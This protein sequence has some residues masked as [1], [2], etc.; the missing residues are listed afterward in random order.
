VGSDYGQ[1]DAPSDVTFTS[2][3]SATWH[4]CG[5]SGSGEAICWGNSFHGRASPPPGTF[6]AVDAGAYHGCG[7]SISS[8]LVCW[9]SDN[10]GNQNV[11]DG[12]TVAFLSANRHNTCALDANGLASCWGCTWTGDYGQC[13]V[14]IDFGHAPPP[15]PEAPPT[16]SVPPSTPPPSIPPPPPP[17]TFYI[18]GDRSQI[19]F[20]TN[21]ECTLELA[22]GATSLTSSCPI[23]TPS[24]RRLEDASNNSDRIA[25][26]ETRIAQLEMDK[27]EMNEQLQFLT[28]ELKMLKEQ[29][30]AP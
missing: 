9:G 3:A 23:N 15:L 13:T 18:R 4:T 14:P 25:Q 8:N 26:L 30:K 1:C 24:S 21:D 7:I 11:P 20:G 28:T 17:T 10:F 22:S 27:A 6:T 5:L 19:V 12:L 2:V 29:R 16:P